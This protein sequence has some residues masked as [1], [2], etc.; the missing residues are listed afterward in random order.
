MDPIPTFY[1]EADFPWT[2]EIFGLEN[3]GKLQCA[4]A[5]TPRNFPCCPGGKIGIYSM[6]ET[7]PKLHVLQKLLSKGPRPGLDL[8]SQEQ[9]L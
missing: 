4:P 3:W 9:R 2:G 1:R 8:F 6:G 5:E 7:F